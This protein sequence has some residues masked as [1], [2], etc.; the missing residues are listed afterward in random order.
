MNEKHQDTSR[1]LY[2]HTGEDTRSAHGKDIPNATSN[3]IFDALPSKIAAAERFTDNWQLMPRRMLF[4]PPLLTQRNSFTEF[5][6]STSTMQPVQTS[7]DGVSLPVLRNEQRR[8]SVLKLNPDRKMPE[9]EETRGAVKNNKSVLPQP[10]DAISPIWEPTSNGPKLTFPD[11]KINR[12]RCG[13]DPFDLRPFEDVFESMKRKRIEK[14]RE[15]LSANGVRLLGNLDDLPE[16]KRKKHERGGVSPESVGNSMEHWENEERCFGH[17]EANLQISKEDNASPEKH[18]NRVVK[19]G[20][21]QRES[22]AV[23]RSRITNRM[24]SEFY[25]QNYHRDWRVSVPYLNPTKLADRIFNDRHSVREKRSSVSSSVWMPNHFKTTTK[26]EVNRVVNGS[27]RGKDPWKSEM[28]MES[29][30]VCETREKTPV[31]FNPK[32]MNTKTTEPEKH[33]IWL[34]DDPLSPKPVDMKTIESKLSSEKHKIWLRDGPL[35]PKPV[36]GDYSD[37]RAVD[38]D[39]K[40]RIRGFQRKS[41]KRPRE[42]ELNSEDEAR[43]S[44]CSPDHSIIKTIRGI[45]SNMKEQLVKTF[46]FKNDR[47]AETFSPVKSRDW[48]KSTAVFGSPERISTDLIMIDAKEREDLKMLR[49]L[50]AA[51][52]H[53]VQKPNGKVFSDHSTLWLLNKEI[54]PPQVSVH[55][56]RPVAT[57]SPPFWVAANGG[58]GVRTQLGMLPNKAHEASSKESSNHRCEICNSTFPLRRLLNRHLKTHSFYKRYACSFCDKGFNDTFDLKRHV[59]THTGI[60]PFKCEQCDKSFTQ[61]CSLEAHQTRVHGLVHKFGFRERRSK[62]FVCEDCGATFRDNQSEFMNHM[63]STHPDK[64]KSTWNKN[65]NGLCSRITT[66]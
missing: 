6:L 26:E 36:Q 27:K 66:F 9:D 29:R 17:L 59:R 51:K 47:V 22:S 35:R 11:G 10:L 21:K 2:S 28:N 31:V 50:Q 58:F 19:N 45:S 49:Q 37:T 61:R 38:A 60:K 33:K 34:R 40:D 44:Q 7:E 63:T 24:E 54:K 18:L 20:L 30:L 14:E 16:A 41:R 4:L 62:M 56:K 42:Q 55:P 43:K 15:L 8:G 48:E 32:E 64:D 57:S 25:Y 5:C 12:E 23:Q 13:I 65:S 39:G 53:A 3:Q 1:R 46:G 52:A